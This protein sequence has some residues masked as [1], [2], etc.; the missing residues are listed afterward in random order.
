[1]RV[2]LDTNVLA[3]GMAGEIRGSVRPPAQIWRRWQQKEFEL[4]VSV[5]LLSELTRALETDWFQTR[6]PH[7]SILDLKR[8][9]RKQ[10]ILIEPAVDIKG[11]ASHWQDDLI[12]AAAV[13]AN[14]DYLVT[15]D[16]EFRRVVNYL[17]VKLRTPAEFLR[18]LDALID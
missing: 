3:A 11:I 12:L 9:L 6:L 10:A 18:E 8:D 14:A 7:E 2:L 1:M 17:G 15:G 4:I 16:T 5:H 13:S